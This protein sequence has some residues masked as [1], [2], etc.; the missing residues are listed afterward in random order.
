MNH[1]IARWMESAKDIYVLEL[2]ADSQVMAAAGVV[3]AIWGPTSYVLAGAIQRRAVDFL[4]VVSSK[5][6]NPAKLVYNSHNNG[7]W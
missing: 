2:A 6:K 3:V 1:E 7:L 5:P 4:A